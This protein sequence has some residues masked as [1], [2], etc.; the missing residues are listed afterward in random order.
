MTPT[1]CWDEKD[2]AFLLDTNDDAPFFCPPSAE[3]QTIERFIPPHLDAKIPALKRIV[4]G[5]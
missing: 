4:S 2:S 1:R 3:M 5:L